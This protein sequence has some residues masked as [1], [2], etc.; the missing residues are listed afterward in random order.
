MRLT[1]PL[2]Q[3]GSNS[4]KSIA[5]NAEQLKGLNSNGS[6]GWADRLVGR[7]I[8]QDKYNLFLSLRGISKKERDDKISSFDNKYEKKDVKVLE[9]NKLLKSPQWI[10]K[11][12]EILERDGHICK[13]CGNSLPLQMQVM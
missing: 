8:S 3:R 1:K 7:E 6:K 2:L 11:K 12:N 9:Y 4:S 13:Q 5:L 10:V